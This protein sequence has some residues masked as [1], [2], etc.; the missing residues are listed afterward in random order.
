MVNF[1]FPRLLKIAEDFK[2]YMTATTK[3]WNWYGYSPTTFFFS[4]FFGL[5][6]RD[7]DNV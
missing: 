1:M 3:D 4:L 7:V 6:K 2:L 5:Q